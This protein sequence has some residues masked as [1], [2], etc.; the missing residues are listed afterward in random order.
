[1][2]VTPLGGFKQTSDQI[3][4]A[5]SSWLICLENSCS[6]VFRMDF[7][8]QTSAPCLHGCT[9]STPFSFPLGDQWYMS[10]KGF[11]PEMLFACT[12]YPDFRNILTLSKIW[13]CCSREHC[14]ARGRVSPS[15]CAWCV[16]DSYVYAWYVCVYCWGH[17]GWVHRLKELLFSR[18]RTRP[19]G[20]AWII[21]ESSLDPTL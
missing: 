11:H 5:D 3:Q 8:Q 18:R 15:A 20:I 17:R 13:T 14:T 12:G 6:H 16:C 19:K 4:F 21:S 10:P 2:K 7:W 9:H 1:M